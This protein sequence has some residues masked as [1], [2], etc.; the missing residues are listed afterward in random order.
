M[1]WK[2][3]FRKAPIPTV[4]AIVGVLATLVGIGMFF[5]TRSDEQIEDGDS[6]TGSAVKEENLPKLPGPPPFG[7]PPPFRK[8]N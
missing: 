2:D 5:A 3:E 6:S 8:A 7:E 1:E 4:A